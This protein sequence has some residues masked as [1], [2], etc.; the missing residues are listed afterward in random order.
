MQDLNEVIEI[1]TDPEVKA[2]FAVLPPEEQLAYA[3]RIKWL[4]IAHAHQ[5]PASWD[6]SIALVLG[7]R[8]AGKTRLAAE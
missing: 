3:A 8:G 7:G 5:V 4:S 6:W 2:H 1:L